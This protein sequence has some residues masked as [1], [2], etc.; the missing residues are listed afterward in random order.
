M[1]T[2]TKNS[3]LLIAQ[4][5]ILLV[6]KR[7]V[8][9]WYESGAIGAFFAPSLKQTNKIAER[10]LCYSCT[11]HKWRGV[12]KYEAECSVVSKLDQVRNFYIFASA[13]CH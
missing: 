3:F 9:K 12:T 13:N 4:L 7:N 11:P 5:E 1:F 8:T 6:V 2:Y 10:V